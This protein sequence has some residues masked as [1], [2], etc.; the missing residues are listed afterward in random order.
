MLCLVIALIINACQTKGADGNVSKAA[1]YQD[2]PF[3]QE[4][5]VKYP[6]EGPKEALKVRADRNGVIQVLTEEGLFRTYGGAFLYPGRLVKDQT[7]RALGDKTLR[8]LVLY[9]E[10]L[11]YLDS[12]A[13]LSNAWAGKL[14]DLHGVAGAKIVCPSERFTFLVA[15]DDLI[16][17]IRSNDILWETSTPK[18]LLMVK[19]HPASKTHYVLS[20]T[21][22]FSLDEEEGALT[23]LYSG[24]GLTCFD[25]IDEGQKIAVGTEDGYFIFDLSTNKASTKNSQLPC[26]AIT[27][28]KNIDGSL[29][30]GS[31]KGAFRERKDGSYDYYF[32]ER[33]LVGQE[34]IDIAKGPHGEVLFLTDQGLSKLEFD[35]HTLYEKAMYFEDQVR[36]R[37]IRFGF[38]ASL[39]NMEKGNVASGMLKDSDND[40]LWTA[41]YLAGQAFRYGVNGDDEALENCRE[42]LDAMERL[43]TINPVEGF[44]SRSFNRSGYEKHLADPERWQR[45]DHPEWDWKATTSSDEAIGHVFAFGVLAEVVDEPAIR[46]KAIQLLDALMQHV[47]DHD[48]YLVDYDGNPTLWGKWNP[49]YV[50]GFPPMVGDRKLNSSNIIA[51]LQTAYHFTQKEIYKDKAF[52]LMQDHGYLQNLMVPMENIGKAEDGSDEWAAMLSQSWNHSDDEMYFLG[53]WG[54]YRYAFNDSLKTQYGSAIKDH[55]EAERP[56]KDGLWNI[57]SALV[58]P[59]DYDQEEAIWYLKQYPMD[60]IDW[61]MVNS[62]RKDIV[63]LDKNFREQ[64]TAKVLPPDE[65]RIR[66]HNANRFALDGGGEGKAEYSAGDIWLLPYWMGRYLGLISGPEAN[67]KNQY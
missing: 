61:T 9:Q 26:P 42:S 37:H 29:W 45:S 56:E 8:D 12:V 39:G 33:W 49:D 34:V 19:Y 3:E 17:G 11:V 46:K 44:P 59:N 51:M 54:L 4:V 22:I 15:G 63:I 28:I 5:S 55:W 35:T 16:R 32:G 40:G 60:L 48:F 23:N 66:R 2:V 36:N 47:V 1:A 7:Y 24:N 58:S 10:Q 27:S 62:H 43:Y 41:M 50:N 52:E 20:K 25:F 57:F 53:Y 21:A 38:N 18:E 30:I 6:F 65:L 14:F 67:V 13:V 64:A 31:E